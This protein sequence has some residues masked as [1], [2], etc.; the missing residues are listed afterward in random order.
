ML[1]WEVR[2][3]QVI[4]AKPAALAHVTVGLCEDVSESRGMTAACLRGAL[5]RGDL[6]KAGCTG[7]L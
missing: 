1:A 3:T 4:S 6:C 2:F 5:D 7:V